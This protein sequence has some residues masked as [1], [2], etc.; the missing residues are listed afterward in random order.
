MDWTRE[1]Q[2]EYLQSS[3]SWL[4]PFSESDGSEQELP[5]DPNEPLT[6]AELPE[7][8]TNLFTGELWRSSAG[9]MSSVPATSFRRTVDVHCYNLPSWGHQL[10]DGL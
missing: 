4:H 9:A 1:D 3:L 6:T 5:G 2:V 8:P 10:S 7:L